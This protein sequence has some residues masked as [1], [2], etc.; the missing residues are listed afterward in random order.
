MEILVRASKDMAL[1]TSKAKRM[2]YVCRLRKYDNRIE[3]NGME[4]MEWNGI[5]WNGNYGMD[6]AGTEWNGMG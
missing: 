6:W 5:R 3:W 1:R 2:K 4:I